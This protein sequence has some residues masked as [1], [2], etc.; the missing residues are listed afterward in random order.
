LKVAENRFA[1]E[2]WAP[3]MIR[4]AWRSPK[5][6]SVLLAI[7]SQ[8]TSTRLLTLITIV[9]VIVGLYFGRTILVP[10]ALAFVFAFLLTPV[11][12]V[13]E[14]TRLGRTPSVVIVLL[15]VFTMAGGVA[16]LAAGQVL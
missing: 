1:R 14:R 6:A 16:W 8:T 5:G 15:L 3:G 11:V 12:C 4:G 2:L 13:V 9:V 10:L 7:K